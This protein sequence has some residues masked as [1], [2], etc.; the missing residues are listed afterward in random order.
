MFFILFLLAAICF[1][2]SILAAIGSAVDSPEA[3]SSTVYVSGH[4]ATPGGLFQAIKSLMSPDSPALSGAPWFPSSPLSW[5]HALQA[6]CLTGRL[7]FLVI[8]YSF[9]LLEW[10]I[11]AAKIYR[12]ACSCMARKRAGANWANGYSTGINIQCVPETGFSRSFYHWTP[13]ILIFCIPRS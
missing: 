8:L 1:D 12:T 11:L 7:L 6:T 10:H 9:Y 3:D 13:L 2:S 5:W 4:A